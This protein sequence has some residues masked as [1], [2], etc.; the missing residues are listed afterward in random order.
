MIEIPYWS[1]VLT[2]LVLAVA[3][4]INDRRKGTTVRQWEYGCLFAMGVVGALYGA[5]NDAVT[6][7]ISPDY[8]A[9]GKQ[10]GF[11]P[12]LKSHAIQLGA[13]AG[14]S[15]AAIAC[16]VW[17]FTLRHTPVRCRCRLIACALWLPLTSA[18]LLSASAGLFLARFAPLGFSFQL[19]GDLRESQ[20]RAF[21]TVWWVH[22][23]AYLGLTLGLAGG[24]AL[25]WR[26]ANRIGTH[27]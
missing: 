26:H 12:S 27:R 23:G 21:V 24:I 9:I 1:R 22:V 2:L 18:V 17:Q 15:A 5:V 20:I 19:A 7:S 14:F 8:F 16:A 6:S 10:L 13:E 4:V 3:M 11:G 25:T